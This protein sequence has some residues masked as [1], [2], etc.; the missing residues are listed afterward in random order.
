VVKAGKSADTEQALEILHAA[1]R[2]LYQ[3]LANGLKD[4]S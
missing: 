1:G 3:L 4:V 2:A